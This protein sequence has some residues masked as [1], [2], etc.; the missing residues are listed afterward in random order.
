MVTGVEGATRII[1]GFIAIVAVA[2]V[3]CTGEVAGSTMGSGSGVPGSTSCPEGMVAVGITG[4]EGDFVDF[5][6]LRCQDIVGL[7]VIITSDGFGGAFGTTDGPS[8]CPS[9]TVL[10]GLRGRSFFSGETIRYVEIL[11]SAPFL[12]EDDDGIPDTPPP[13]DKAQCKNGGWASFNNPSF[14]NQGQ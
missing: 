13:T 9:G 2:T 11:C 5:L 4:R 7:S 12:D 1:G 14:R 6:A 10:T 8:D 3:Q